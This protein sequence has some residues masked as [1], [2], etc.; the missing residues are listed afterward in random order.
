VLG[1][2]VVLAAL[3]GWHVGINLAKGYAGRVQ[4]SATYRCDFQDSD[5]QVVFALENSTHG[6][7]SW[8]SSVGPLPVAVGVAYPPGRVPAGSGV[9]K[10]YLAIALFNFVY[11]GRLRIGENTRA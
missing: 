2:I 4:Y 7:H 3:A 11:L 5:T 8:R 10:V 6:A 9:S 1:P